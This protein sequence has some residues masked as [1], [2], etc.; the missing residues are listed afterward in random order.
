MTSLTEEVQPQ[1]S[2][3]YECADCIVGFG[4][5]RSL[6]QHIAQAHMPAKTLEVE[7]ENGLDPSSDSLDEEDGEE[8]DDDDDDDYELGEDPANP[9]S[10]NRHHCRY[11]TKSFHRSFCLKRHERRHTGEKPFNCHECGKRFSDRS[12]LLQHERSRHSEARTYVCT[13]CLKQFAQYN[14]L[15]RHLRSVHRNKLSFICPEPCNHAFVTEDAWIQ[16]L[17][18]HRNNVKPITVNGPWPCKGSKTKIPGYPDF[19]TATRKETAG[20]YRQYPEEPEELALVRPVAMKAFGNQTAVELLSQVSTAT[21]TAAEATVAAVATVVAAA[22]TN[23][24]P[25]DQ[26]TLNALPDNHFHSNDTKVELPLMLSHQDVGTASGDSQVKI[27]QHQMPVLLP[28]CSAP[29]TITS[30]DLPA[31]AAPAPS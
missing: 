3:V 13:A 11:C 19:P 18:T 10:K 30:S 17:R 16:H 24:A 31:E 5:R 25:S 6:T 26:G 20:G 12:N 22:Q 8:D 28:T 23:W 27:E 4:D 9:T 1:L 2:R 15:R 14:Y 29:S 7:E 21:S